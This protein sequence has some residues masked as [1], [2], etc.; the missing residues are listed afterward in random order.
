MSG[1]LESDWLPPLCFLSTRRQPVQRI[2]T[3]TPSAG[4][5]FDKLP[6]ARAPR[7]RT[8]SLSRRRL[9]SA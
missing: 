8:T 2:N 4:N 6:S 3:A 5:D 7:V 9:A 1:Y